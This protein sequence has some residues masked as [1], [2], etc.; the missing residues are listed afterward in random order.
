MNNHVMVKMTSHRSI[1]LYQIEKINSIFINTWISMLVPATI[2]SIL[3]LV[4]GTWAH[5][6]CFLLSPNV[7]I[8]FRSAINPLFMCTPVP[9]KKNSLKI[10]MKITN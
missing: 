2:V 8:T 4:I 10:I 1:A 3:H 6:Q 9:T 5:F 7:L